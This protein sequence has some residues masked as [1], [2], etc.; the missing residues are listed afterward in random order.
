MVKLVKVFCFVFLSLYGCVLD[1]YEFYGGVPEVNIIITFIS[2]V[3]KKKKK[4]ETATTR[5]EAVML[6]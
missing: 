2:N 4:K 3:V 6:W 1:F 5:Q